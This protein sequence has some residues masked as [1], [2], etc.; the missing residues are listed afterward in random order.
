MTPDELFE[1]FNKSVDAYVKDPESKDS[2]SHRVNL[3]SKIVLLEE[4]VKEEKD[5]EKKSLAAYYAA[6]CYQKLSILPFASPL[7]D[8]L[9]KEKAKKELKEY[10][11]KSSEFLNK[12]FE[13][14]QGNSGE[15][16]KRD[17]IK[18]IM[19]YAYL[20]K[21]LNTKNEGDLDLAMILKDNIKDPDKKKKF[22]A[23]A[24][25][26]G[27][28]LD[29]LKPLSDLPQVAPPKRKGMR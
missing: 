20:R 10:Q 21:A 25:S 22:A 26:L 8:N 11:G 24:K 18:E 29:F 9:E 5:I 4:I 23:M 6:D 27:E 15:L 12:F 2:E 14:Y 28:S 17:K 7:A 3:H 19:P 1:E 16:S 13:L